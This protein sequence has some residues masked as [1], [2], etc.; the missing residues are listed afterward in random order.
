LKKRI[1]IRFCTPRDLKKILLCQQ[2]VIESLI[3]PYYY[4]PATPI[5]LEELLFCDR[6]E[7]YIL[8]AFLGNTILGF[9]TIKKWTGSYYGYDYCSNNNCYSIEDTLVMD[10]YR[11]FGTQCRLWREAFSH[12]PKPSTVLCTIHPENNISMSNA[13]QIGFVPQ[14]LCHPYDASPR[15]ILEKTL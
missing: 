13:L 15:I 12:L 3:Q 5:E 8:G 6:A 9:M 4:Y 1:H 14:M 11:G 10:A 2:S 7:G